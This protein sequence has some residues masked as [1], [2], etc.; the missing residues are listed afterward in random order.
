MHKE[1]TCMFK[2]IWK[3]KLR[4]V[5][6]IGALY[7]ATAGLFFMAFTR[8]FNGVS[9]YDS[10]RVVT[11]C[12]MMPLLIK[13]VFQLACSPFYSIISHRRAK[14]AAHSEQASVSVIIPA[15]NEEVGILKTIWSAINT[16]YPN[17]QVVVVND[18]STDGTHDRVSGFLDEYEPDP[19]QRAT[20]TYLN[21]PN[22]GKARAMNRALLHAEGDIVVTVDADSA[23]DPDAIVNLVKHFDD[24]SVGGVAGNVIV[25][26]RRKPIE[27]M[28]QMEYLY[29]FFF[30]RS[31][32]LF[33]SVYIIGGAAAAYRRDVL[34]KVGGFDHEIITEDIEMSTRILSHGYKTR[35]A[36][37]A[38]VY[39]EGPS[40]P[41]GLCNQR[42]RWKYGRLLTFLK[43][44]RLFFSLRR[45]HNPYLTCFILPLA[46]YAELLLL[47]EAIML[48]AFFLYTVATSDY[49]PL[50][51]VIGLLTAVVSMQILIDPKMRFHRN[52][53]ILAPGAWLLFYAMDL[54]EF[55][56]LVRSLKRLVTRKELK[57]Q[58]W[59][60]V[61]VVGESCIGTQPAYD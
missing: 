14:R 50:A 44:R 2:K 3:T 55:Q 53:L 6:F 59:V 19:V 49:M 61:G 34:E 12:L 51:F 47:T 17:L 45:E 23:M 8:E 20:V 15:W 57:W 7:A 56:A 5:C 24:P 13:Y 38:V 58:R 1:S 21:V 39:T 42:L 37:D 60:R 10:V 33:N 48:G 16:G 22:G 4:L 11:L 30:K 43:H 41:G 29:G 52:L 46:V 36:C 31:D 9:K 25:G 27:W 28:Q 18:G 32:S 40:D 26:N 54:V 35:Y